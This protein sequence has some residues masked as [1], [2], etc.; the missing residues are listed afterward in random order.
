MQSRRW[1]AR[2]GFDGICDYRKFGS[3]S[4]VSVLVAALHISRIPG[5][6]RRLVWH[7]LRALSS[8][9]RWDRTRSRDL[10]R[11]RERGAN[12]LARCCRSTMRLLLVERGS[13]RHGMISVL[14]IEG[15]RYSKNSEENQNE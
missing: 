3:R 5:A 11:Y 10:M 7:S 4:P 1:H 8:C 13:G 9:A 15:R 2:S 14:E 12:S 6:W